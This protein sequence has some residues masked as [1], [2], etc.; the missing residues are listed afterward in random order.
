MSAMNTTI[1]RQLSQG[2]ATQLEQYVVKRIVSAVPKGI[3][4]TH[5]TIIA[6]IAGLLIGVSYLLADSWKPWILVTNVFILIHWIGDALDGTVARHRKAL[7][8][9][10]FYLD[11]MLDAL[12]LCFIFVGMYFSG[13]TTTALPLVFALLYL[14]LE[15]N[16][17]AQAIIFGTFP[18]TVGLFGPAEAQL[19]LMLGN[20]V[21]FTTGT[22]TL[23]LW[24][25]RFSLLFWDIG[26]LVGVGILVPA[27]ATLF[28]QTVVRTLT[29]DRKK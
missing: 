6:A 20:I 5:L 29:L 14:L 27:F 11:H 9:T 1:K 10:G 22:M 2:P 28:S 17:M 21:A 25:T 12:T 13:L 16:V 23:T 8:K 4:P 7:T 3:T 18:I 19:L 15:V 26:M 24:G